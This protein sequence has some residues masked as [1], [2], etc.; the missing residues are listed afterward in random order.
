MT[1]SAE[2]QEAI[3]NCSREPIHIPGEIQSSGALIACDVELTEILF[4][5]VTTSTFLGIEAECLLGKP[6]ADVLDGNQMRAAR[7]VL[8]DVS[9]SERRE[10][11]GDYQHADVRLQVAV[12]VRDNRAVFDF[13]PYVGDQDA[14]A[15]TLDR[16]RSL[17]NESVKSGNLGHFLHGAVGNLRDMTGFD[18]VKAY[19]FLPDGSG[20]IV[21]ESREP[22]MESFLGLR[23]PD[24]DIPAIAK[25]LYLTTPI[26]VNFGTGASHSQVLA[27]SDTARPLDMSLSIL[28][29]VAGV[30]V[31]YLKNMNVETTMS[32]PIIVDEELWG[33]FALHNRKQKALEPTML[34]TAELFGNVYSLALQHALQVRKLQQLADCVPV[35]RSLLSDELIDPLFSESWTKA[36][37]QLNLLVPCSGIALIHNGDLKTHGNVPSEEICLSLQAVFLRDGAPLVS[38]SISLQSFLPEDNCGDVAGVLHISISTDDNTGLLLF[39]NRVERTVEWAGEPTKQISRTPSGLELNPRRSFEM[40][41]ESVEGQCDEWTYYDLEIAHSLQN[42]ASRTYQSNQELAEGRRLALMVKELNHRVRNILTLVQSLSRSTQSTSSSVD[43]YALSL[44]QRITAL[45]RAHDLL[46]SRD[47]AT[48]RLREIVELELMPYLDAGLH[49]ALFSG[50]DVLLT[51]E[52]SPILALVLHELTS[53]AVKYGALSVADGRVTLNWSVSDD[54]LQIEWRELGGPVVLP[55]EREGFGKSIIEQAIPYELDGQAEIEF[56]PAGVCARFSL[57]KRSFRMNEKPGNSEQSVSSAGSSDDA[58]TLVASALIVEDNFFVATELEAWFGE[59]GCP[60]VVACSNVNQALEFLGNRTFDCCV[61]DVNLRGTNSEPVAA[62]LEEMGIPFIF[63]SGYGPD[64]I[65]FCAKYDTVVLT[66]PVSFHELR[67]QVVRMS[68]LG[69]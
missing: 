45:A 22:H 61:L 56:A 4:A 65:A 30:H 38:S 37:R 64:A 7:R 9:A 35:A 28:R 18:R 58:G 44:Q 51:S 17:I 69:S 42:A 6:V 50:P 25:K 68:S 13:L 11:V 40:Y 33:L 34:S 2:L 15:F 1:T 23:F 39:R 14:E 55:P 46:T 24:T 31:Q 19:R 10:V 47:T 12:H 27:L 3:E 63:A 49:E 29:G 59:L 20:E 32:L 60:D 36:C 5:S 43:E 57:G 52:A 62:R 16:V 8:S 41:R 53:N 66:K 21:A 54:T 67:D 48:V 26:R